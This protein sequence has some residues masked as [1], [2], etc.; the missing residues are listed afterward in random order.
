MAAGHDIYALRNGTIP[1]QRQMLV[2]TGM[3]IGLPRG[4]YGRL[5]A[6]TGMAGKHGIAVGGGVID[7]DYTGEIK[8]ILRN[9]GDTSYEFKAGDRIP[10]L[11]VQKIQT[12]DAMEI[13]NPDDTERGTQ[14][15]GSSDLGPKQLIACE[16]LKVKICFLNPDPQ[17]NSYFDEEDIHIPRSL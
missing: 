2:D 10:H 4:T 3:A 11:I 6:R 7:A 13:D 14:G 1:A 9:H 12:Q 15:F 5:A 8:L 16:E 17:E